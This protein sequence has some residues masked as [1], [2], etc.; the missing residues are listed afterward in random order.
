MKSLNKTL[1]EKQLSCAGNSTQF[2]WRKSWSSISGSK[3]AKATVFAVL[4]EHE[5]FFVLFQKEILNVSLLKVK[6]WKFK[7]QW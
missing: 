3:G 6:S 2:E 7:K 4:Q 1:S 5:E